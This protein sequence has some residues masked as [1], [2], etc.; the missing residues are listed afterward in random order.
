MSGWSGAEAT[1]QVYWTQLTAPYLTNLTLS[2]TGIVPDVT[3]VYT[4]IADVGSWRAWHNDNGYYVWFDFDNI[5]L[6]RISTNA[7]APY[8]GSVWGGPEVAGYPIGNY[9]PYNDMSNPVLSTGTITV[10]YSY[11]HIHWE[12]G[13]NATQD[14]WQV[15]RDGVVLQASYADSN[16]LGTMYGNGAGIT[17][18]TAAQ[19]GAANT[20]VFANASNRIVNVETATGTL[21]TAVGNLITATGTLNTAVG[22][23]NTASNNLNSR[24]TGI[25]GNTGKWETAY[26]DSAS[27]TGSVVELQAATN[28]LNTRAGDL[29]TATN[30]IN[31]VANAA[32]PASNPSNFISETGATIYGLTNGS[33]YR[34]DWGASVSGQ[35]ANAV[36][37]PIS[38]PV[39]GNGQA[40]T[41]IFS[42]TDTR[43]L[44]W[45]I[46]AGVI[47]P[48]AASNAPS[49]W[50][51]CDGAA[52]S[53]AT[54]TNLWMV[55]GATYGAGDA[56]TTFNVPNLVEKFPLGHTNLLGVASGVSSVTLTTNQMP[57]HRHYLGVLQSAATS[58]HTLTNNWAAPGGSPYYANSSY[59]LN[60][61]P[62]VAG[63]GLP[64]TNMPPNL[65]VNYIIKY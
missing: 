41:N 12:A 49:G 20:Q 16:L 21:N 57:V 31:I 26:T 30:V 47:C 39:N 38:G 32:Y 29:E 28:A 63:G 58:D 59:Y 56:S 48:Y 17:G 42:L 50:L 3:G 10:A 25:E 18:I 6:G 36:T 1:Q 15:K 62:T 65:T 40:F 53:R 64:H 55:I 51:L 61:S 27:A 22:N 43:G 46:P 33:A 2:G 34:G 54:Y 9:T 60:D 23:L 24:V 45:G 35:V 14:C 19:V 52:V 7:S 5:N 11:P 4:Q 37:N 13:Y 44:S 8:S